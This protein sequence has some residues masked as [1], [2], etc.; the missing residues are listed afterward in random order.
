MLERFSKDMDCSIIVG[1]GELWDAALAFE[2][3]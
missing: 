2:G 1:V 3:T